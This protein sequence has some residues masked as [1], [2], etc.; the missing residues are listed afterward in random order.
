MGWKGFVRPHYRAQTLCVCIPVSLVFANMPWAET[1]CD[2]DVGVTA[3]L[4]DTT[5]S[6]NNKQSQTAYFW[7][8]IDGAVW[9][10]N[11]S[12]IVLTGV[13]HCYEF[14]GRNSS[15]C[16]QSW[17]YVHGYQVAQYC[18]GVCPPE[19]SVDI[20]LQC[21]RGKLRVIDICDANR[22]VPRNHHLA[23]VCMYVCIC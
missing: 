22:R 14:R 5:V 17:L 21:T 15:A 1:G 10:M 8:D 20:P 3:W 23:R 11:K 7:R 12:V 18:P 2:G 13:P 9:D 16:T 19:F 4:R 6:C